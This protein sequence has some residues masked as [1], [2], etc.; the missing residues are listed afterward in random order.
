MFFVKATLAR[1]KVEVYMLAKY[2]DDVDVAMSVIKKGWRRKEIEKG[3]RQ[4][5]TAKKLNNRI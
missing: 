3:V 2:V 4:L 5:D 1:S